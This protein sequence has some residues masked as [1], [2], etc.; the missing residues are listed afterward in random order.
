M[1]MSGFIS[2]IK[3]GEQIDPQMPVSSML[4]MQ[5]DVTASP[6]LGHVWTNPENLTWPF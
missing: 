4:G 6:R 2:E 3:L 1:E 5:P